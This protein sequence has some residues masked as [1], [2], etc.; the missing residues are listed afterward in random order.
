MT[1]HQNLHGTR[2]RHL[3]GGMGL[4]VLLIALL[5]FVYTQ[6]ARQLRYQREQF[7]RLREQVAACKAQVTRAGQPDLSVVRARVNRME[8]R[9]INPRSLSGWVAALRVA[10]EEKFGF[11]GAV[12]RVGSVEKTVRAELERGFS[13]E[14]SLSGVEMEAKASTQEVAS[15][16]EALSGSD[17]QPLC[18]L[19]EISLEALPSDGPDP[20]RVRLKWLVAVAPPAEGE[21]APSGEPS[22]AADLKPG[23]PDWGP[24]TEPFRSP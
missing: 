22:P 10:A 9:L 12:V 3:L 5:V 1:D 24:R 6:A 13:Y 4:Q 8:G 2:E 20:V 7:L 19:Q 17:S 23:S 18:P 15:L 14:A 21:P 11:Q 16:L